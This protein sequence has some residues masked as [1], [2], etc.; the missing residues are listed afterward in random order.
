[1]RIRRIALASLGVTTHH[2]SA[3]ATPLPALPAGNRTAKS[4]VASELTREVI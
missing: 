3:P 2:R 1:M 4:Q